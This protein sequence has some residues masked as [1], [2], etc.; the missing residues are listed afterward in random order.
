MRVK[1][2]L[3]HRLC[4]N[5]SISNIL[6]FSY[7]HSL[8]FHYESHTRWLFMFFKHFDTVLGIKGFQTLPKSYL[9][10]IL[11]WIVSH[12]RIGYKYFLQ[13][14][15]FQQKL[16]I[17]ILN[18]VNCTQKICKP[19]QKLLY[20]ICILYLFY[21]YH[22]YFNPILI[23]SRS[24]LLV[25]SLI[26]KIDHLFCFYWNP[27]LQAVVYFIPVLLYQTTK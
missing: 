12:D 27:I 10:S 5:T 8:Y 26:R 6:D 19:L 2:K 21:C 1:V 24:I 25:F 22:T 16:M 3:S 14:T 9:K 18:Q 23:L 20:F 11:T 4:H 7:Q 15:L 17:R 13:G